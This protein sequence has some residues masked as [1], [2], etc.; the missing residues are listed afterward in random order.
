MKYGIF[1]DNKNLVQILFG[2]IQIIHGKNTKKLE[3]KKGIN[4]S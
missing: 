3:I 1:N 4:L 2:P